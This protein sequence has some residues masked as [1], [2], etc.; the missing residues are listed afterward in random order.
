MPLKLYINAN[1]KRPGGE[2]CRV[3]VESRMSSNSPIARNIT[4][5]GRPC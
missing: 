3:A 4:V 5:L 2:S 1:K